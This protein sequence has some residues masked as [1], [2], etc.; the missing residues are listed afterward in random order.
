[1]RFHISKYTIYRYLRGEILTYL[2]DITDIAH[3]YFL[4]IMAH[5]SGANNNKKKKNYIYI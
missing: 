3:H 5:L 2:I 1:M 4:L